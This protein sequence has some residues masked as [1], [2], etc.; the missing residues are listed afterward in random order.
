MVPINFRNQ[1]PSES[2]KNFVLFTKIYVYPKDCEKLETIIEAVKK[3]MA[4]A[5]K[6][7]EQQKQ[8]NTTVNGINTFA[9]KI[10]PLPL[11][12]FFIRLGKLFFKSKHSII[13]SNLGIAN[14]PEGAGVEKVFFNLNVSNNNPVNCGA[15]SNGDDLMLTF[16]RTIAETEV[17]RRF[18]TSLSKEGIKVKILSNFREEQIVL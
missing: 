4:V 1:F 13:F 2:L 14:M 16:T 17:E 6:K 8:I 9:F 18:F 3:Q 11:K 10:L 15:L 12:F 7:E 5:A